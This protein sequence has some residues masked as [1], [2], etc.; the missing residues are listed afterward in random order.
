MLN[1]PDI[2]SRLPAAVELM[3]ALEN[4]V[5]PANEAGSLPPAC[6]ADD[7]VL[8]M[9]IETIFRRQWLGIG[10]AGRLE[11]AGDYETLE[12]AGVPLI[13]LRDTDGILRAFANSC[14][15]RGA[16]LLDGEGNCRGIRCPFHSW[17]YK[18]DGALAGAPK[19][20]DAAGFDRSQYGLIEFRAAELC[21]L[22]FVCLDHTAPDLDECIGDFAAL[23]SP[24]PMHTLVPTRRR[25]F[26]VGCNWKI[27]LEVFNEYYHLPY[28][29]PDTVDRVYGVPGVP[30]AAT[31]AYASQ[32]GG[33]DGTGGL[34]D[35]Q[36]EHA[37]PKMPGLADAVSNG[38]RYTW[39]F[40]NMTFG[41]G[42]DALWIY[43]ANPIDA[44]RCHVTQTTC[45]PKQT[46]E[47][48]D[49]SALSE[50]YYHRMDA[51]IEEDV[52][53][54]ENQQRGLNS[55]LAT[56]GRFSPILEANVA[57]FARWYA[58]HFTNRQTSSI[59]RPGQ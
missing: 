9:E 46:I 59:H 20:E 32:Y 21:G 38:V 41:A 47:L 35:G 14:R 8:K 37:L 31:G 50:H 10:H 4:C 19:M 49:F 16:R 11:A 5:A 1:R 3:A 12:I 56:Q 52:Q 24:W 42:S 55:P 43:E 15:H 23:H 36:Q 48:P 18:L 58:G 33:T 28:V 44:R 51:A 6:Y 54:L 13:V 2:E 34:L 27:F 45:F 22:G 29:H 57:S 39:V 7:A 25:S 40:P 17:A 53:A 26:E 30:H